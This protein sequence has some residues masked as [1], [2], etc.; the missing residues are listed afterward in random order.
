MSGVTWRLLLDL[1]PPGKVISKKI[2]KRDLPFHS[3]R[4]RLGW[5]KGWA[6]FLMIY[7]GSGNPDFEKCSDSELLFFYINFMLGPKSGTT[8]LWVRVT[9][10]LSGN[11]IASV[12]HPG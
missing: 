5:S 9:F 11:G 7:L 3:G 8:F 12:N 6:G 4:I 10:A 2:S 1:L